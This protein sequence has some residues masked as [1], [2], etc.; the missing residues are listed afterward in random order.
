VGA[1]F[2]RGRR[3]WLSFATQRMFVTPLE[4]GPAIAATRTGETGPAAN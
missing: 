2:L 3:T 4:R 1:D